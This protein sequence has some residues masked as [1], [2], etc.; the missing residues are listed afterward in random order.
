MTSQGISS[1]IDFSRFFIPEELTPLYHTPCYAWLTGAQRLR[2][3]QLHACY[4]NEQTIFFES[5]MAQRIL[6]YFVKQSLPGG[7]SE[8]LRQFIAEEARHSEMFRQLN[9][10]CLPH[11]YANGDFY[12]IRVPAFL[13]SLLRGW[14][15][16]PKYFPLFV[17]LLLIEEERSLFYAK[18]FLKSAATLEPHF[19]STQ[20]THLA[21]EV[22]HVRWDEELLDWI[23]P[24][25]GGKLR[26]VNAQIFKWLVS[27][28]FNTPKR[29]GWRVV[30]ELVAEDS[31]LRP[32]LLELKA[33][34]RRLAKNRGYH[35]SLYSRSITPKAFQ[36]FDCCPEFH[37]IGDILLG[38][39]LP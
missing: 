6:S 19:I 24:Q 1:P 35:L 29:G 26:R 11:R 22:G 21:D 28:Y 38:Y 31:A 2:Y 16:R 12:F 8:G 32:R 5:V 4:F 30:E 7:L 37:S 20:K 9:R 10:Q 23:W 33:A 34:V 18:E 27:E 3:N 15:R 39:T 25:T 14:V 17:W 36:R 13:S